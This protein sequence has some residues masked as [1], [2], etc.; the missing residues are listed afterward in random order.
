MLGCFLY[1][2]KHFKRVSQILLA[3]GSQFEYSTMFTVWIFHDVKVTGNARKEWIKTLEVSWSP[4]IISSLYIT[5]IFRVDVTLSEK[6]SWWF[7]KMFC[8]REMLRC[9]YVNIC[10]IVR[11]TFYKKWN[12]IIALLWILFFAFFTSVF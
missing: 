11:F 1:F 9:Q 3:W 8:Y 12:T 10:E 7:C 6:K 5:V 2:T 4:S